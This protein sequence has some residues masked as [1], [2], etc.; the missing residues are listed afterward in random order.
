MF[1]IGS[2]SKEN[3]FEIPETNY[4]FE[5]WHK[6]ASA[7]QCLFVMTFS[8]TM[9]NISSKSIWT[10]SS[11]FDSDKLFWL[12][13]TSIPENRF[14]ISDN[15]KI[16][17]WK[18]YDIFVYYIFNKCCFV[19]EQIHLKCFRKFRSRWFNYQFKYFLF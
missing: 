14:K 4:C 1:L 12:M 13:S 10:G 7:C 11:P 18:Q 2:T 5:N 16:Q 6:W 17:I 8:L 19:N 15:D 3:F 9:F